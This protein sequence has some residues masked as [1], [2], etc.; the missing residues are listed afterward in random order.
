MNVLI[1]EVVTKKKGKNKAKQKK[2]TG[3]GKHSREFG[4]LNRSCINS[5]SARVQIFS[6]D[7]SNTHPNCIELCFFFLKKNSRIAQNKVDHRVK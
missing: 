3:N 2:K 7:L 4:R 1:A 6:S 5:P